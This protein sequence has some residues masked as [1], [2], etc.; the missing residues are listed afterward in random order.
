[1]ENPRS[2]TGSSEG[3][4]GGGAELQEPDARQHGYRA[5][6]RDHHQIA[7]GLPAV[8]G[9]RRQALPAQPGRY[10]GPRRFR[11]RGLPGHFLLRGCAAPDRRDAGSGG[12]D[13]LESFHGAGA[14]PRNHPGDQQDRSS[15]PPMSTAADTRSTTT[16]GS[17]PTGRCWCRRRSASGSTSSWTR[18][19]SAFRPRRGSPTTR[20]RRSSSIPITI[21]PG[22]RRPCPGVRGQ[23][24]AGRPDPL[25]VQRLGVRCGGDGGLPA[26]SGAAGQRA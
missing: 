8:R 24:Q 13:A 16:W 15:R 10:A 18:S 20:S 3:K 4:T 17:I 5:G 9:I 7:G 1:M 2:R 12:A 6:A 23:L 14:Q 19:F 11:L 26:G 22:R 25:L 21:L